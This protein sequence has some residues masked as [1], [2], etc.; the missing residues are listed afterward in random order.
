MYLDIKLD[1]RELAVLERGGYLSFSFQNG[2][3]IIVKKDSDESGEEE[4]REKGEHK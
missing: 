3:R 2:I 4:N 1:K